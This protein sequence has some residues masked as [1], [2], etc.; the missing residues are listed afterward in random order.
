[1]KGTLAGVLCVLAL[2]P[3]GGSCQLA[4]LGLGGGFGTGWGEDF[5]IAEAGPTVGGSV[6]FLGLSG[7]EVGLAFDYSHF[8]IGDPEDFD[9]PEE[10][11]LEI[12]DEYFAQLDILAVVRHVFPAE[13]ARFFI[14]GKAGFT[15]R[16]AKHAIMET[17]RSGL[18]IGPTIGV[19]LPIGD[20]HLEVGLDAMLVSYGDVKVL[21]LELPDSG[22]SGLRGIGRVGLS[23]P[24]GE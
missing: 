5:D 8:G 19:L 6:V 2:F 24:L 7:V 11:D 13:T 9:V 16:T 15:R 17:W 1:M 20:L 18:A 10:I 23:I 12:G 4:R 22:A 21:D 3:N 14:G